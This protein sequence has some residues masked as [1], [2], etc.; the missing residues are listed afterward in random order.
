MDTGASSCFISPSFADSLGVPVTTGHPRLIRLGDS[1]TYKADKELTANTYLGEHQFE[2]KFL[3]MP[4]P[5]GIDVILGLS[6]MKPNNVW[7]NAL[8]K[9][10]ILGPTADRDQVEL[11]CSSHE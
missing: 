8:D 5:H 4:L 2:L 3:I 11:L 7:L 9:R 6:F 1:S 10:V